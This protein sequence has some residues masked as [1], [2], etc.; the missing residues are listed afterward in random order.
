MDLASVNLL[1]SFT[2]V[3]SFFDISVGVLISFLSD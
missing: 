3:F 1:S 2:D